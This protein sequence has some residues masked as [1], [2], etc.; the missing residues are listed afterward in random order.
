MKL[1][2]IK[3]LT[4]LSTPY[5]CQILNGTRGV[6]WVTAK[7]MSDAFGKE[8]AWWMDAELEQLRKAVSRVK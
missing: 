4:G 1:S 7:K 6:S 3:E 2:D 8:P 5:I